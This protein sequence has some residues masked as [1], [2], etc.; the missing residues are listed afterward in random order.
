MPPYQGEESIKY[1][2]VQSERTTAQLP[3][4]R[5]GSTN[6]P[7]DE[8]TSI[9]NPSRSSSS[10]M[11]RELPNGVEIKRVSTALEFLDVVINVSAAIA[12]K[13][14][15]EKISTQRCSPGESHA[16]PV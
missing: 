11:Q 1:N 16:Q 10:R 12:G 14:F 8:S 9:F 7:V 6:E 3:L 5:S 4:V 13:D 15:E 2:H